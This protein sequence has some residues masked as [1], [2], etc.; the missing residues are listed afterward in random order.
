MTSPATPEQ[1][2]P[3]VDPWEVLQRIAARRPGYDTYRSAAAF[4]R[5][6]EDAMEALRHRPKP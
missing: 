2:R 3:G 5:C 4:Y 1:Q 6:R